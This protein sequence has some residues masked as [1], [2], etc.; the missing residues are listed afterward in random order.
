MSRT[1]EITACRKPCCLAS[2]YRSMRGN[3]NK[4]L[5]IWVTAGKNKKL[6]WPG[7]ECRIQM[8]VGITLDTYENGRSPLSILC[9]YFL[10]DMDKTD[11]VPPEIIGGSVAN[12]SSE[13]WFHWSYLAHLWHVYSCQKLFTLCCPLMDVL[14]KN[15]VNVKDTW[16]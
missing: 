14:L 11:A 9:V 5:I 15:H 2:A 12:S 4:Q 7:F 6:I 3:K 1:P 8:L 16:K 13:I 10:T